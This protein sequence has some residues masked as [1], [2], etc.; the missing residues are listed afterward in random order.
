MLRVIGLIVVV[1]FVLSLAHGERTGG[2][3][4]A[5]LR[6]ET[7]VDGLTSRLADG[8]RELG[9]RLF[10]PGPGIRVPGGRALMDDFDDAVRT[11]DARSRRA[12]AGMVLQACPALG[13]SCRPAGTSGWDGEPPPRNDRRSDF[14]DGR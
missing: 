11:G 4:E 9:D 10:G 13:L 14:D 12:L 2:Y 7:L 5:N 6:A 1:L 3:A 8:M